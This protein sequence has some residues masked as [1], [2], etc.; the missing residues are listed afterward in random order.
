MIDRIHKRMIQWGEWKRLT[1]SDGGMGF[2]SQSVEYRLMREQLPTTIKNVTYHCLDCGAKHKHLY[3][4]CPNQTGPD[5]DDICHG[6]L[7]PMP[8]M[9]G[10]GTKPNFHS[11][12]LR[13]DKVSDQINN[14]L[15][16]IPAPELIVVAWV[17]Y[18]L[19]LPVTYCAKDMSMSPALFKNKVD[20]LH[21]WLD[22]YLYANE[23]MP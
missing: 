19:E 23:R 1:V 8:E 22:A 2:S 20:C 14:G 4:S 12:R 9:K 18:V 3:R 16:I 21:Y 10:S 15:R 6:L 17:R 7:A 11:T 5:P 13:N